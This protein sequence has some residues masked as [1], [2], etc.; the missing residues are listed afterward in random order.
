M[1]HEMKRRALIKGIAA[2][3]IAQASPPSACI[4]QR[5]R[6]A[7]HLTGPAL[8]GMNFAACELCWS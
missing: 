8:S 6:T 2:A 4:R 1:T 3:A 5:T 7:R